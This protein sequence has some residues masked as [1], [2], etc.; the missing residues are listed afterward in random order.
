MPKPTDFALSCFCYAKNDL[1]L[2]TFSS[3]ICK[4]F[5]PSTETRR[6]FCFPF[7]QRS[8]SF[9]FHFPLLLLKTHLWA[10]TSC[11]WLS[12]LPL[13]DSGEGVKKEQGDIQTYSPSFSTLQLCIYHTHF[14]WEERSCNQHWTALVRQHSLSDEASTAVFTLVAVIQAANIWGQMLS[15]ILCLNKDGYFG[16]PNLARTGNAAV[17]STTDITSPSWKWEVAAFRVIHT[18][19]VQSIIQNFSL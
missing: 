16:S 18:F 7:A 3:Q 13:L 6:G 2:L 10:K 1:L 11:S 8:P 17:I 4:V 14:R 19:S 12:L 5:L 15:H 9:L